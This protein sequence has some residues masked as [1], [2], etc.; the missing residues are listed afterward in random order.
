MS[1]RLTTVPG[2]GGAKIPMRW[3]RAVLI[4]GLIMGAV[5]VV[6]LLTLRHHHQICIAPY[7]SPIASAHPAPSRGDCSL[8]S[9]LYYLGLGTIV[10]GALLTLG[11][12][13]AR[14]WNR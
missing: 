2:S 9:W 8:V 4:A 10:I 13:A 7:G 11:P 14:T 1:A 3:L 12:V 6:L 5:G